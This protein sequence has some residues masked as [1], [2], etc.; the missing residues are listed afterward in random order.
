MCDQLIDEAHRDIE[1]ALIF[2]QI[3]FGVGLI[4]QQPLLRRKT[5]RMLQTLK[6]QITVFAAVAVGTQGR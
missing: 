1:L 6:H 3:A 2:C 4:E 5:Q